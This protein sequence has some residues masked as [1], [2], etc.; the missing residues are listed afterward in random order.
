MK[1]GARARCFDWRNWGMLLSAALL[2]SIHCHCYDA[3]FTKLIQAV[4]AVNWPF[5]IKN[6]TDPDQG[7]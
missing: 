6:W 4:L 5:K 1:V 2:L 3:K 7:E